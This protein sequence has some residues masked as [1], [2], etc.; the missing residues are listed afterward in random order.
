MKRATAEYA[1]DA[2]FFNAFGRERRG[3][4]AI[5]ELIGRVLASPGFRA[6][7]KGPLQV[8]AI[9]FLT[10]TLAMVHTI[11]ETL[12]QKQLSGADLGPRR[13]HIFRLVRKGDQGWQT[14]AFIVS[15][16]RSGGT[17]PA[18]VQPVGR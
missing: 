13:T 12:G 3:K 17:L 8:T 7:Q 16:E 1:E 4:A 11:E 6:G 18:E 14:R 15:D 2:Y 10:A 9:E 5:Q